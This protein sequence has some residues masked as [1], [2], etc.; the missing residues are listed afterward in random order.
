[1]KLSIICKSKIHRAVVT[2]ADL[3]YIG[4]IGVDA[5]LLERTGIVAGERVSVWNVTTGARVETYAIP[6]PS[7]S[8]E[9]VLNGAAA[10]HFRRGDIVIIA[11]FCL[12]DEPVEPRMILVDAKNRFVRD[13]T[14]ADTAVDLP[15]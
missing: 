10:H 12:T 9:V 5:S 3:D 7:G 2:G 15:A 6:L 1:M 4:S 14:H 13:L 8:G 11:A